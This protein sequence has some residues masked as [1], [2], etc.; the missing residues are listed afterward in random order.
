MEK[1]LNIPIVYALLNGHPPT[2]RWSSIILAISFW[3]FHFMGTVTHTEANLWLATAVSI[4][5]AI[6]Y[7]AD[8][9]KWLKNRK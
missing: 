1:L 6:R 3:A 2:P 9:I 5:A 8:F 4:F 7:I